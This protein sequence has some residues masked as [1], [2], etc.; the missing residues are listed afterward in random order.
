MLSGC[1]GANAAQLMRNLGPPEISHTQRVNMA[2]CIA[3]CP[4][5]EPEQKRQAEVQGC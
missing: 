1:Q 2:D 4:K 3:G 5:V